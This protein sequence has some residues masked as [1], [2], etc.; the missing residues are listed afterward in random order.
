MYSLKQKAVRR[1]DFGPLDLI[2]IKRRDYRWIEGDDFGHSVMPV[3]SLGQPVAEAFSHEELDE[4]SRSDQLQHEV[5]YYDEAKSR[6]RL[7]ARARSLFQ[8]DPKEQKKVLDRQE[9]VDL[10]LRAEAGDPAFV[11]TDACIDNA[12]KGIFAAICARNVARAAEDKVARCDQIFEMTK[13]PSARTVRRWLKAY[14]EGGLDVMALRDGYNRSGNPFTS[15]D[16][17]VYNLVNKH[18]D[19]WADNRRPTMAG[20]HDKL[21]AEIRDINKKREASGEPPL[22]I[23]AKTTLRKAIRSIPAFDAYAARHGVEAARRKFTIVGGG[24]EIVRAFQRL[25]MDGHKLQASTLAVKIGE[26]DLLSPKDKKDAERERLV[27]HASICTATRCFTGLR[28]SK[29][30]NKETAN[31]T[32]RMSVSDKSRYAKA[33]GC[34]SDWPMAARPGSVHTDSGSAWIANEFRASVADLRATL[35]TAPVGHPQM[36]GHIERAFGTIDRG[37]LPHFS[38]R[39]FA[40][41]TSKGEYD[42]EKHASIFS[43]RIGFIVVRYIVDKYHHTPHSSLDNMTP[44]SKWHELVDRY[45][46]LPPPGR[47]ELRNVFGPRIERALDHRGVRLAGIHYQS[48]R[49][50]EYRRKVGDTQVAVKFDPEDLGRVSVWIDAGWLSVPAMRGKFDGVHLDVWTETMRDLR[51]RNLVQASV[52]QHYVDDAL[53]AIA[54]MGDL[55]MARANIASPTITAEDLERH[56]RELLYGFDIVGDDAADGPVMANR[57]GNG[58]RDRFANATRILDRPISGDETT[59]SAD[60]ATTPP[61]ADDPPAIRTRKSNVKLEK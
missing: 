20:Q 25:V 17:E 52:S 36:R 27:L 10:L 45:G 9:I 49:L 55:A 15:L 38:G 35:E 50:Q 46:I 59:A 44:Y 54:A 40:N 19:A 61:Q 24:M 28:F 5:R 1:F 21:A 30:E 23:P 4:L 6:T 13:T 31:A 18:A 26:W 53:L 3:Q 34:K 29:S 32:L 8:L 58:S 60:G 22:A 12:M 51:R 33:A 47:D 56:E 41:V 39:T 43:E 2:T 57:D 48:P 11:R 42:P 7:K 16:P 37:L 14:E